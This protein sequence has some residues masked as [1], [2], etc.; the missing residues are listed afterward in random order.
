MSKPPL[1]VQIESMI[2]GLELAGLSRSEIAA[3]AHVS[4]NT[5]WR[6]ANGEAPAPSYAFLQHQRP[7]KAT[8][9]K[10]NRLGPPKP[11]L[12]AIR[13]AVTAALSNH[14][15]QQRCPHC[16]IGFQ[17]TQKTILPK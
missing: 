8:R 17:M 12:P 3:Q 16:R 10:N 13:R 2:A 9:E 15:P 6:L 11:T 14:H 7:Y 1:A 4:K 5:V